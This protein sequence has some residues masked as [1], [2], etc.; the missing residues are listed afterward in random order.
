MVKLPR[1]GAAGPLMLA[2]LLFTKL[3]VLD[4]VPALL[5][6]PKFTSWPVTRNVA[7]RWLMRLEL[8]LPRPCGI[9]MA[10]LLVMVVAAPRPR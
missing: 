10:P 7:P 9:V 8:M 3:P 5:T 4:T 6:V 1:N 2:P